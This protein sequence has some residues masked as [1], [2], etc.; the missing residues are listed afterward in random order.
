M[1]AINRFVVQAVLAAALLAGGAGTVMAQA[2][3]A[4]AEAHAI[5]PERLGRLKQAI[6]DYVDQ[7]R[8]AGAVVQIRQDGREVFSVAAGW[9]DKEAKSPMQ[10]DTIFR[11]AS[12]SKALT[13]VA[14]MMLSEDGKLLLSDPVGKYLPEWTKTTV[15][16]TTADGGYSV[17]PAKRPITIRDLLTHTSGISYGWGPGEKAWKDAGITGWYFADRNEPVSAVVA[18]MGSLPMAAQPGEQ[19]VYGYSTDIL[20]VIVEKV[21]GKTLDAFLSERLIRPLGMKDTSFYLPRDKAGRLATVYAAGE[22]GVKP[23]PASGQGHYL[24]GPRLAFSGG[25]GLL[26][27]A[28][29]YARFLEMLRGG[30]ELDGRRYLSRKSVELMTSN[31][32][33]IPYEPGKGFGLGF[34]IREDV[35]KAGE[36]GSK[37]EFAWGGAYH[38][39]YWVDPAEG[40]TVVY[41]TQLLPAG[42]IDDHG[43]LRT[44]I[45]QALD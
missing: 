9:R 33:N 3:P 24:D 19:F 29:D 10:T 37:G 34:S 18:R 45:Y 31:H 1:R 26:S 4:A 28:P 32:L 42:D 36:P 15:A 35:G 12:Q 14:I 16:V 22:G 27:T 25:A 2:A 7:G 41:M 13:S 11:I 30:G 38:S 20:G 21:S 39:T 5:S 43:K 40:L 23:A 17:A 44:L 6:Q 8:L